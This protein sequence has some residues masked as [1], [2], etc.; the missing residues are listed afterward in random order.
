[1]YFWGSTCDEIAMCA[2]VH[3]TRKCINGYS[4]LIKN[5][6][7]VTKIGRTNIENLYG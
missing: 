4:N 3:T 5:A 6:K 1:M 2:N 7:A